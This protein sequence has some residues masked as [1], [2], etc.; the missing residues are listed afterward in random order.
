MQS[1]GALTCAG[2]CAGRG[3]QGAGWRAGSRRRR[4]ASEAAI[5]EARTRLAHATPP[6]PLAHCSFIPS[7]SPLKLTLY[8][9]APQ[10]IAGCSRRLTSVMCP[11]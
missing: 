4:G 3:L 10:A 9:E 8:M 1:V 11:L 6:Q 7:P 2:W 5:D